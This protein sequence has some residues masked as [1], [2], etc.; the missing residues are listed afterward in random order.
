LEELH[1]VLGNSLCLDKL[2]ELV[3]VLF[4]KDSI[5]RFL[6]LDVR[7]NADNPLDGRHLELLVQSVEG[8]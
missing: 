5:L 8:G 6:L 2:F 7:K 4:K 1:K 3:V